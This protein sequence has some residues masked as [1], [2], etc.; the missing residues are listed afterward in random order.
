MGGPPDKAERKAS[1]IGVGVKYRIGDRKTMQFRVGYSKSK[2]EIPSLNLTAQ[3]GEGHYVEVGI[4]TLPAPKWELDGFIANFEVGELEGNM[5]FVTL[6]RRVT[7]SL[8]INI[9]GKLLEGDG[10]SE[11]WMIGTRYHF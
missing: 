1:L 10:E 6:E 5:L 7:R 9:S 3:E 11:S 8:G 4:R 2:T